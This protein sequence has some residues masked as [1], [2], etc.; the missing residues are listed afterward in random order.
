MKRGIDESRIGY[1]TGLGKALSSMRKP[2]TTVLPE[3]SAR[4][5]RTA[6]HLY[7]CSAQQVRVAL[8][9]RPT[10]T[11]ECLATLSI[12][13]DSRGVSQLGGL[14]LVIAVG[15]PSRIVIIHS[16]QQPFTRAIAL[17]GQVAQLVERGPE[18]A[19]VGGSTPSLATIF[20]II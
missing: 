9:V 8:T 13:R 11:D 7:A 16:P 20:S 17:C 15:A 3:A 14:T 5:H 19:G 2:R 1:A 10:E 18:K 4:R 12:D 6:R